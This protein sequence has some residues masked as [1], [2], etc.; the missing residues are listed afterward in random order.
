MQQCVSGTLEVEDVPIHYAKSSFY[1]P[2]V[3]PP[4]WPKVCFVEVSLTVSPSERQGAPFC[5]QFLNVASY[6]EGNE[7]QKVVTNKFP[8]TID[9]LIFFSASLAF[10]Y[11]HICKIHST[12]EQSFFHNILLI[13][14]KNILCKLQTDTYADTAILFFLFVFIEW[15][16]KIFYQAHKGYFPA[17]NLDHQIHF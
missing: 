15:T 3:L 2:A 7:G 4:P 13:V 12:P 14:I 10:L 16:V 9:E 5:S 6:K 11:T 17:A 1:L 8:Q